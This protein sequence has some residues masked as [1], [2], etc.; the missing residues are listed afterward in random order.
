MCVTKQFPNIVD[1]FAIV[2][3]D[4]MG[5]KIRMTGEMKLD[6]SIDRNGVQVLLWIKV[7]IDTRYVNV[8]HIQQKLTSGLDGEQSNELPFAQGRIAKGDV[9]ARIF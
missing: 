8:V 9:S 5:A 6:D 3:I 1:N 4:A 2:C 7:V